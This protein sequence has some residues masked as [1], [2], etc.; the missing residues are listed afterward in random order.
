MFHFHSSAY[1]SWHDITK[2]VR[3]CS[4]EGRLL[5]LWLWLFNPPMLKRVNPDDMSCLTPRSQ[6]W[7]LLR[8]TSVTTGSEEK[9]G[10][11]KFACQAW[12][13]RLIHAFPKT[14]ILLSWTHKSLDVHRG[15]FQC[16]HQHIKERSEEMSSSTLF[17]LPLTCVF[18]LIVQTSEYGAASIAVICFVILIYMNMQKA[19]DCYWCMTVQLEQ[20]EVFYLL[21]LKWRNWVFFFRSWLWDYWWERSKAPLAALHR[22]AKRQ[23]SHVWRYI[24]WS[25][26]GSHCC[27]LWKVR[28]RCI[29]SLSCPI[30]EHVC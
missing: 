20:G 15:W 8:R 16:S 11:S 3:R 19:Q 25:K 7:Y 26:M 24:D 10:H 23:G 2:M 4:L 14:H 1:D 5:Q 9:R 17:A 30:S 29:Y 27:P 28:A 6:P 18:L 13:I 21:S 12:S 22:S